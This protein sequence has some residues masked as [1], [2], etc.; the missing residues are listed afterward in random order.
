[1]N[2]LANITALLATACIA[3]LPSAASAQTSPELRTAYAQA[4][5]VAEGDVEAV[6]AKQNAANALYGRMLSDIPNDFGGMRILPSKDLKVHV[7]LKSGDASVLARYTTDPAYSVKKAKRSRAELISVME[8]VNPL[9]ADAGVLYSATIEVDDQFVKVSTLDDQRARALLRSLPDR[10]GVGTYCHTKS[11]HYDVGSQRDWSWG[12][13][14]RR[15][16]R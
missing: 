9:L 8:M 2:R 6:L 15:K 13:R 1:M 10:G 11:V 12:C 4:F 3:G 5:G 14:K 7:Y 16:R